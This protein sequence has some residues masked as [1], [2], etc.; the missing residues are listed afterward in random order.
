MK[1]AA[2][3]GVISNAESS[4]RVAAMSWV[5]VVLIWLWTNHVAYCQWIHVCMWGTIS[6]SRKWPFTE[7]LH[8]PD[9]FSLEQLLSAAGKPLNYRLLM[10]A[11]LNG[12][13]ALN[14]ASRCAKWRGSRSTPREF[15]PTQTQLQ[16]KSPN[17]T[18]VFLH[19]GIQPCWLVRFLWCFTSV[20]VLEPPLAGLFLPTG[21]LCASQLSSRGFWVMRLLLMK[22]RSQF[23][24]ASALLHIPVSSHYS[25]ETKQL[26]SH[27]FSD[28]NEMSFHSAIRSRSN[29]SLWPINPLKWIYQNGYW[30]QR[31]LFLSGSGGNSRLTWTSFS[32]AANG[33]PR[34][35]KA[36]DGSKAPKTFYVIH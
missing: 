9:D 12:D 18:S 24:P 36:D 23:M 4:E 35:Y 34:L 16:L 19:V 25:W 3:W 29:W 1:P 27:G 6:A 30:E 20:S 5:N 26:E 10:A 28:S 8:L 15:P 33:V 14:A 7:Q 31:C 11:A 32:K 2:V 17:L 21:A 22:D 13:L